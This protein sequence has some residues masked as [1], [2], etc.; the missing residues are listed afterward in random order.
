MWINIAI[1]R[2]YS[3]TKTS[4]LKLFMFLCGYTRLSNCLEIISDHQKY[5][6]RYVHYDTP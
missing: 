3:E 4:L 5:W 1:E 2:K 6:N